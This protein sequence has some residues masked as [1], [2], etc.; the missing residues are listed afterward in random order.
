[1]AIT[2][3]AELKTA[4]ANWTH[5][6]DLTS[7]ADEFIDMAEAKMNRI[8][9][10]SEME[11]RAT[12]TLTDEYTSLPSD[13][14]EMRNIQ[15]N[16]TYAYPLEYRT[17][18]QMDMLDVNESS[19]PKYYTIVDD[20]IQVYPTSSG[21][22]IE[23]DYYKTIAALSDSNTTNFVLTAWPDLYLHG[24]LHYANVFMHNASMATYHGQEFDRLLM[25]INN[26]SKA[27]KY[28]GAP[29]QV[30]AG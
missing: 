6:S 17:P 1:M 3:Y 4:I 18:H 15:I 14:L 24:S 26:K 10:L 21:K 22:V 2:T 28:S 5:R 7:Y 11:T 29:L 23:I 16:D 27:R 9:R 25:E 19:R 30:V 20:T 8:L 12:A 13:Y